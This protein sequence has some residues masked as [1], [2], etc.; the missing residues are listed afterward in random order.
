MLLQFFATNF[1]ITNRRTIH[2]PCVILQRTEP[3]NLLS[4]QLPRQ[5]Q[6]RKLLYGRD[7]TD[8]EMFLA[9]I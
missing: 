3:L 1:S 6:I 2:R 8:T 7:I 9:M 4:K 5:G